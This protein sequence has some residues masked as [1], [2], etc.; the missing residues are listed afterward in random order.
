[1]TPLRFCFFT[2]FYPPYNFGGDGIGVQRLARG[3]IAQGCTVT[4]VHELDAYRALNRGPEPPPP[5]PEPG[6]SLVSLHSP[7]G[8]LSLLLTHQFGRPIVHARRIR[9]LLQD[10]HFD[11]LAFHNVSLVGGPGLLAY[12]GTTPKMYLAHEHWLVCQSHTLWRH[13]RELCT[14]RQC[15]RCALRY[16]RPPQLWRWTGYLERQARNVDTFIA[17]SEFSR[18]KHA[19]YGFGEPMEV[20]PYFLPQPERREF[21]GYERPH[22]RPYFLFVGRLERLK[23]LD[24]V[25]DAWRDFTSADLVV[26]GE[27]DYGPTLKKRAAGS[28]RVIF[29]GRVDRPAL[30]RYYRHAIA[31]IVPSMC[32]ETFG[33]ITLEAFQQRTPVIARRVGP[34][35]EIV[36][37]A[38]GGLTFST[39]DEL[40][41][42][43][44]RVQ[45]DATYRSALAEA[46]HHAYQSRYTERVV[47]PKFLELA[48]RAIARRREIASGAR[49]GGSINTSCA[50]S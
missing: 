10:S 49:A 44:R 31:L 45:E 5:V 27:G 30:D 16:R 4:V 11:V 22:P 40:L 32:Y 25:I 1:M 47:V 50:P 8:R 35:P 39:R 12:G 9:R 26:A 15:V 37:G 42:A 28:P 21:D 14:G 46:G 18:N 7:L 38:G 6:L 29:L 2:T 23:G 36:E 17:M 41:A 34:L 3:L 33:V 13:N 48:S 43:M 24:D 19:E 20:V